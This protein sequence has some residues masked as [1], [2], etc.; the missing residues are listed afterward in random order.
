M[1]TPL[2]YVVDDDVD[3]LDLVALRLAQAGWEVRRFS[4]PAQALKA[5]ESESPALVVTDLH[6]PGIDGHTLLKRARELDSKT[7]VIM[8]SGAGTIEAAVAAMKDGAFDFLVKPVDFSHLAELAQRAMEFNELKRENVTLRKEVAHMRKSGLAPAGSSEAMRKVMELA[9]A[10][11]ATDT[12]VLITGESGVGKERLADFIQAN[13]QR[14]NGPHIKV[15]CG[16]LSGSLLESELFGH[17]K[18]A[19]TGATDRRIGRFEQ[20]QNGTIFLDEIGEMSMEAQTRLL[21]VL[22]QRELQRVGGAATINLNIRVVCATNKDLKAEVAAGKFRE[23]LYY[24]VNVF[25]LRLPPLRERRA[26]IPALSLDLLRTIRLRLD[27]GPAD[28]SQ[29]ALDAMAVYDWPGNIRELENVLQRCA[30]LCRSDTL[31]VADLPTE[32]TQAQAAA[33]MPS[34]PGTLETA[35]E[36]SER[37]RILEALD[38]CNWNM[39]LAAQRL[40]ISRSTLYVKLDQ[41]R[42]Q[43]PGAGK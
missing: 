19:F 25:P 10:V 8:M 34:A 33:S 13:S 41:Y 43:R 6:M 11:A 4:D 17:E 23:D 40:A 1:N 26:D 14:K 42:I 27:R 9:G 28:I 15:N 21:R 32:I 3:V 37:R 35:R 39:S 2:V 31:D 30:I 20:A 24:R 29:A 7:S 22:Q 18:G 38:E 36:D 5:I 16:A 12:T